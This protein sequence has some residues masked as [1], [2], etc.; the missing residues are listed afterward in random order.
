MTAHETVGEPRQPPP[1]KMSYEEFLDWCDEDT[2]AEWVRGKVQM[3]MPAALP[4]QRIMKFLSIVLTFWVRAR[5]LGEII[6][7]PFQMK[8]P[9]PV[10]AGREPDLIFVARD[11][12][13]RLRHTHL[14]GPADLV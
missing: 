13:D 3:R 1:G 8:L 6:L 11:H 12:L 14:D 4:H 2:L 10:D 5:G 7:P 9:P